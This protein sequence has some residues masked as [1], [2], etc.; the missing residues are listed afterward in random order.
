MKRSEKNTSPAAE[1]KTGQP[2]GVK[3]RVASRLQT[4]EG[5]F[6]VGQKK[7]ALVMFCLFFGSYNAYLLLSALTDKPPPV[8]LIRPGGLR[9]PG[10][11]V[12]G[13]NLLIYRQEAP[14]GDS[15]L[16]FKSHD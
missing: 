5:R 13:G 15:I 2:A 7:L 8:I 9:M 3:R 16:K 12:P 4:W 10:I 1:S 14:A 11:Y 6:S